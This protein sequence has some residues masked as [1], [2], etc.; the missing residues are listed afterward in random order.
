MCSIIIA[1]GV[2]LFYGAGFHIVFEGVF[3]LSSFLFYKKYKK[4]GFE[5]S[6]ILSTCLAGG[7]TGIFLVSAILMKPLV[8]NWHFCVGVSLIGFAIGYFFMRIWWE[9]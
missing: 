6:A 4:I 1:I 5:W 8:E 3:Y 7:I 9:K 2:G